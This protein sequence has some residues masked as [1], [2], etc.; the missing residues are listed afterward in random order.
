[1]IWVF[2]NCSINFKLGRMNPWVSLKMQ[3]FPYLSSS[4]F[5]DF[6]IDVNK[7]WFKLPNN[8]EYEIEPVLYLLMYV[9]LFS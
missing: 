8:V 7:N 3:V 9:C 5:G 1:M 2:R 6:G 4:V